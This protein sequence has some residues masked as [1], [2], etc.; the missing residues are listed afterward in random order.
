VNLNKNSCVIW[1]DKLPSYKATDNKYTRGYCLI[2]GGDVSVGAAKL[3]ALSAL[4]AGAGVVSIA[5]QKQ[6][7]PIYASNTLSIMVKPVLDDIEEYLQLLSDER[8]NTVVIGPGLGL[9]SK[10]KE[11]VL[12]ALSYKKTCILDADALTAFANERLSLFAAINSSVIMTP[13]A[14]EFNRLFP[15]LQ[16]LKKI[17]ASKQASQ[18]SNA[19][20]V[21]K[22]H[23]TII[24]S[25]E[26][27]ILI[28]DN[29]PPYLATAGSGDVLSGIIAGLVSQG[30]DL[31][32]AASAAVWIHGQAANI[33]GKGLISE[34][35]PNIIPVV[36]QN[37]SV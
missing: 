34:D 12:A 37:I 17:E 6:S 15:E 25:P 18:I 22:G 23:N 29:A 26:G 28:N 35:L 27:K 7:F 32:Y 16:S 9:S 2:I 11:I 30:M 5:C 4:R 3:A 19:T 36:L 13:H 31:F 20:I 14:G 24:A 1:Q 8:I 33:F 21:Y 10:T